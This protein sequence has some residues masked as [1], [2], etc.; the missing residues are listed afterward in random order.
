MAKHG[1][2][3]DA[4]IWRILTA[5][6]LNRANYPSS[7]SEP[8]DAD[9]STVACRRAL[10]MTNRA[11]IQMEYAKKMAKE[12]QDDAAR[13]DKET[14]KQQRDQKKA[15]KIEAERIKAGNLQQQ[16]L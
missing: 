16:V 7:E 11:W 1:S 14:R 12:A 15:D 13:A 2:L 5:A 9:Q 6:G 4:E 10:I 3:P 8:R